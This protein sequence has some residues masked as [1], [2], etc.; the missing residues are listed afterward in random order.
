M[1]AAE[2]VVNTNTWLVTYTQNGETRSQNN[3]LDFF[4][5]VN[6]I[7]F[8]YSE[9]SFYI[10][11]GCAWHGS[12]IGSCHDD[13]TA[14]VCVGNNGIEPNLVARKLT[15]LLLRCQVT[16]TSGMRFEKP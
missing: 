5:S 16:T 10:D 13:A 8:Y 15:W 7:R 9:C 14:M 1:A 11:L 3:V 6:C 2:T 4:I 12:I